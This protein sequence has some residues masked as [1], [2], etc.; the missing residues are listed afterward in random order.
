MLW[1]VLFVSI[2]LY[3]PLYLWS[4]GRLSV[5]EMKWYKFHMRSPE[6]DTKSGYAQRL[7]TRRMLL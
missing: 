1:V 2:L 6:E 3:V 4:E 7:N 5:D